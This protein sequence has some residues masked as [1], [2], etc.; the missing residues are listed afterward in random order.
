MKKRFLASIM[1]VV[2]VL[3]MPVMASAETMEERITALEKRVAGLEA[4]VG[5]ET[6]EQETEIETEVETETEEAKLMNEEEFLN[7]IEKIIFD[8]ANEKGSQ[9]SRVELESVAVFSLKDGV[10]DNLTFE[11]V[12]NGQYIYLSGVL[13]WD[14]GAKDDFFYKYTLNSDGQFEGKDMYS[15]GS[16][17]SSL[18]NQFNNFMASIEELYIEYYKYLVSSGRVISYDEFKNGELGYVKVDTES[19]E[20]INKMLKEK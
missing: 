1:S 3:G 12:N 16:S 19:I 10:D 17:G 18:Q 20:N 13:L 11:Y 6:V 8:L 4:I 15:Y 5:V 9:S 14:N 2:M 7:D